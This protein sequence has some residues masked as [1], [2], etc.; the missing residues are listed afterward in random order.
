MNARKSLWMAAFALIVALGLAA[1]GGAATPQIAA[2]SVVNSS[3]GEP[4][5][6]S[7]S[8]APTAQ[9]EPT[10]VPKNPVPD[11][12]PMMPG[13]TK[14]KTTADNTYIAYEVASTTVEAVTKFYQDELLTHGWEQINRSDSGFGDSITLLRTK[15]DQN[16]SVT[17]QSVAGSETVRVQITLIKK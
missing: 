10:T 5:A 2:T 3:G 13:A 16:I 9:P 4:T 15:P 12:V 6:T 8:A 7:A 11:D 1:C 14:L 17:I